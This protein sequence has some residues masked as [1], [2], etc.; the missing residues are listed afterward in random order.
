MLISHSDL[1]QVFIFYSVRA[2]GG[3][4][5]G[6]FEVLID[7]TLDDNQQLVIDKGELS[8]PLGDSD[9][10]G[11]VNIGGGMNY[12]LTL[13]DKFSTIKGYTICSY[14]QKVASVGS[15]QCVD[16]PYG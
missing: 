10:F 13:F 6:M 14:K 11:A 8:V 16:L 4:G 2:S 12:L 5:I 9:N 15:T 7:L 1:N 3:H